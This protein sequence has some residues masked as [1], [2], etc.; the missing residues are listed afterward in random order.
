MDPN[1]TRHMAAQVVQ[2]A[3]Q[4]QQAQQSLQL[5]QPHVQFS[6]QSNAI[7]NLTCQWQKCGERCES[8]EALYEHVC[9]RHVGRQSTTNLNLT[10]QLGA[11]RTTTAK[12]DRITSHIR[13]HIPLKPHECDFCGKLFKRPRD[14]KKHVKTHAD[15]PD[16]PNSLSLSNSGPGRLGGGASSGQHSHKE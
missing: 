6:V 13:V 9:D 16:L 1:S 5:Q 7:T 4:Q 2:V 3:T 10:C 15:D 11:C 14:L 12:R 8:A